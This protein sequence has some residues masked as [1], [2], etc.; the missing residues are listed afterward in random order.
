MQFSWVRQMRLPTAVVVR[1]RCRVMVFE[2][3]EVIDKTGW[4]A[5]RH[6]TSHDAGMVDTADVAASAFTSDT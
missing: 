4:G 6:K 1:R 5:Q 3:P 2:R